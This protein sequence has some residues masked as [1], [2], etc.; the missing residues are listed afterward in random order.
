MRKLV[1]KRRFEIRSVYI[2]GVFRRSFSQKEKYICKFVLSF[3]I[4]S[5]SIGKHCLAE[6][7]ELTIAY[8]TGFQ[9]AFGH[10]MV[11]NTSFRVVFRSIWLHI[12]SLVRN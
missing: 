2:V 9:M 11:L 5:L 1:C 12:K 6:N 7:F 3:L 8:R 10:K 4:F